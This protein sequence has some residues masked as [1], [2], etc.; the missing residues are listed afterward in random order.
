M[1]PVHSSMEDALGLLGGLWQREQGESK[2][3]MNFLKS[4]CFSEIW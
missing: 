4:L 3:V 1:E 2:I